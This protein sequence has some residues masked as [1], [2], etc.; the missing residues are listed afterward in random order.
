MKTSKSPIRLTTEYFLIIMGMSVGLLFI[1]GAIEAN[2]ELKEPAEIINF[3]MKDLDAL[4][5]LECEVLHN[6]LASLSKSDNDV[7]FY[8]IQ[9][10]SG[11]VNNTCFNAS[12][13]DVH[14]MQ[15]A[16]NRYKLRVLLWK[17]MKE[18]FFKPKLI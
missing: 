5:D 8:N 14:A 2:H 7:V 11:T 18:N 12:S 9:Y 4:P 3:R 1:T 17:Q 16:A 15:K 13:A 6:H 10:G